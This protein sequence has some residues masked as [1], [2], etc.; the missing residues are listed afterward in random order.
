MPAPYSYDLRKKAVDACSRGE[1]KRTICRLMK[2]SRNTLDLWLK[3]E[4]ETGDSL[5]RSP[6]VPPEKSEK[7]RI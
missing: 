7:F 4:Q 1:K 6:S 3:R 2:I 5:K